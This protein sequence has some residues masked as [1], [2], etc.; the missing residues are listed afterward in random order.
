MEGNGE[1][2]RGVERKMQKGNGEG[3]GAEK[4]ENVSS[5]EVVRSHGLWRTLARFPRLGSNMR[6][7]YARVKR[8]PD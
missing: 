3:R 5:M 7:W 8:P 6:K 4:K 1:Q 2:W